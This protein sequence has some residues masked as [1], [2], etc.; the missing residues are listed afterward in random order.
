MAF[1]TDS[2]R[3]QPLWQP[4]PT[5]CLTA[6]GAASEVASLLLHP[7]GALRPTLTL[8][9]GTHLQQL[10]RAPPKS[11]VRTVMEP[12][13]TEPRSMLTLLKV[14]GALTCRTG[15]EFPIPRPPDPATPCL[16]TPQP[17]PICGIRDQPIRAPPAPGIFWA[18]GETVEKLVPRNA[19]MPKMLQLEWSV[20]IFH[21]PPSPW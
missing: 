4:P 16:Q 2:N 11:A 19:F 15:P 18:F 21:F 5:A 1:V 17:T 20:Q 9:R 13:D 10:I 14:Y 12:I 3:P 8:T 7:W 6:S